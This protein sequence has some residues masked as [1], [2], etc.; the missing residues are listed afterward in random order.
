MVITENCSFV[1]FSDDS[2][3]EISWKLPLPLQEAIATLPEETR[4]LVGEEIIHTLRGFFLLYVGIFYHE[5]ESDRLLQFNLLNCAIAK[6]IDLLHVP[7]PP[8]MNKEGLLE[9]I[10]KNA[11]L[12]GKPN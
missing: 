2:C 6:M 7:L 10:L 3:G 9:E 5:N 11:P 8:A 4:L 12:S 1:R